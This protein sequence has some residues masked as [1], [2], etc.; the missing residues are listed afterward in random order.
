M[1]IQVKH[2]IQS[3]SSE[4]SENVVLD[5]SRDS[6]DEQYGPSPAKRYMTDDTPNSY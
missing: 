3:D 2:W 1:V 4:F 6:E 5:V